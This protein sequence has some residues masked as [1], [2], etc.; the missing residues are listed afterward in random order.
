MEQEKIFFYNIL[1]I[2]EPEFFKIHLVEIENLKRIIYLENEIRIQFKNFYIINHELN[3][4]Y[5]KII[6]HL[7]IY[8]DI[9]VIEEKFSNKFYTAIQWKEKDEFDWNYLKDGNKNEAYKRFLSL[10]ANDYHFNF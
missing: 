7:N 1:K 9:E 5:E 4:S 6:Q 2:L 10:M 8:L 3:I